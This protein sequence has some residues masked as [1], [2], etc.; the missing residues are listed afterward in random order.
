[1]WKCIPHLGK[2]ID[3]WTA[4]RD[5]WTHEHCRGT[6]SVDSRTFQFRWLGLDLL[7][8]LSASLLSLYIIM[9]Q[10]TL[11]LNIFLHTVVPQRSTAPPVCKSSGRLWTEAKWFWRRCGV[12]AEWGRRLPQPI[13]DWVCPQSKGKS[14]RLVDDN[15]YSELRNPHNQYVTIYSEL[16]N[17][18][19]Q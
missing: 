10:L 2:R 11:L 7:R 1:M 5:V 17:P 12:A 8:I 18:H 14:P 6:E 3:L 4:V 19:N 13:G 16:R 15:F 9:F